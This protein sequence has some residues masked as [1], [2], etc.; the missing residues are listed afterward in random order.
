MGKEDATHFDFSSQYHQFQGSPGSPSSNFVELAGGPA[1]PA[2]GHAIA[3]SLATAGSKLL[4]YPIE[5]VTTRLQVQ[6]QLRGPRDAPSAARGADAEYKSF[7]D[8]VQKI[9][10]SEGGVRAFYTGC[11]PDVGKGIAD[12]FLFFL[13]YTFVR[14]HQLRQDG[15]KDL[16]IVHELG[17]GVA[18]GSFAKLITTPLQNII[19][20]QQTAALIAARDPS[21]GTTASGSDKLTIRDIARQIQSERGIAGFWAGYSASIILTLNPAITFAVE[22]TL[23]S[24]LPPSRRVKPSPQLTFLLAA[25]SKA[26]ATSLTYP[27]MLAKSRAQAATP[28]SI[29]DSE[30]TEKN[31]LQREVSISGPE[32]HKAKKTTRSSVHKLLSLLS[33]QYA[34]LLTL[35]K[36]YHEEGLSGLYSGIEGEVLKGFLSHGLTM[37]V[38]EKVH[39]GVIQLYYLLLRMTRR[40]PDEAQ[41]VQTNVRAVAAEARE[42]VGNVSVTVVEGAKHLAEEGKKA[43]GVYM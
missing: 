8:G 29:N 21:S 16:S 13:A 2:L 43:V 10:S 40:W 12:S 41:K 36:I 11:T 23:K 18:A 24:F 31:A 17:I 30:G 25:I 14:Q 39:V 33:A 38:K 26:F 5:L 42:G 22:N 1:L 35:R 15:R 9:Y 34:I 20:R 4:V 32:N 27:V 28:T 19:T 7:L 37:M 3:G 6:R